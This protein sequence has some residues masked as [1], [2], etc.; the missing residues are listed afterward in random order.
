MAPYNR[1]D[2]C[3][4]FEEKHHQFGCCTPRHQQQHGGSYLRK[5]VFSKLGSSRMAATPQLCNRL[6]N[7][8]DLSVVQKVICRKSQHPVHKT[9]ICSWYA[10]LPFADQPPLLTDHERSPE[11]KDSLAALLISMYNAMLENRA[12]SKREMGEEPSIERM[13][14]K[15]KKCQKAKRSDEEDERKRQQELDCHEMMDGRIGPKRGIKTAETASTNDS[16]LRGSTTDIGSTTHSSRGS[17]ERIGDSAEYEHGAGSSKRRRMT[18]E[19]QT[20]HS[21]PLGFITEDSALM[22]FMHKYMHPPT[23][24]DCETQYE[25]NMGDGTQHTIVGSKGAK[26]AKGAKGVDYGEESDDEMT[27]PSDATKNTRTKKIVHDDDGNPIEIEE[28]V[29]DESDKEVSNV[30]QA[31][32]RPKKQ[33]ANESARDDS[34]QEMTNVGKAKSRQ[35]KQGAKTL[36]AANSDENDGMNTDENATDGA[37]KNKKG[38]Q[39]DTD[40]GEDPHGPSQKTGANNHDANGKGATHLT[41]EEA[42]AKAAAQKAE[43]R[44]QGRTSQSSL[45]QRTSA[46]LAAASKQQQRRKQ[47]LGSQASEDQNANAKSDRPCRGKPSDKQQRSKRRSKLEASS[48]RDVCTRQTCIKQCRNP[49]CQARVDSPQALA[50]RTAALSSM[51]ARELAHSA[52]GAYAVVVGAAIDIGTK[53]QTSKLWVSDE[54]TFETDSAMERR[55]NVALQQLRPRNGR[56][57][58]RAA[59]GPNGRNRFLDGRRHTLADE[60]LKRVANRIDCE[61][62]MT[63][64]RQMQTRLVGMQLRA[65]QLAASDNDQPMRQDHRC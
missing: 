19:A 52:C 58:V 55:L 33:R 8:V 17:Y 27:R 65:A 34:D 26:G 53:R 4:F 30:E 40:V 47:R 41:T 59:C 31:K 50:R 7:A 49:R 45:R 15:R 28:S 3:T 22:Y 51:H 42:V 13:L 12:L 25:D 37:S 24:A 11:A 57:Y 18:I 61:R 5:R 39:Y 62:P 29:G 63:D 2:H 36:G 20:E 64:A 54:N 44:R 46:E 16:N 43:A 48:C 14:F 21:G 35:K 10:V 56:S 6:K 38:A 23:L 1:N 9:P 60:Q 32:G